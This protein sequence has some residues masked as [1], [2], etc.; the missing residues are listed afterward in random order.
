MDLAAYLLGQGRLRE[1]LPLYARAAQWTSRS[2]LAE[3]Y[4]FWGIAVEGGGNG[5]APDF[6]AAAALFRR[7]LA[8]RPI[9][10]AWVDLAGADNRLGQTTHKTDYYVEAEHAS[11]QA[12]ALAPQNPE[13]WN[14]LAVELNAQGKTVE[15]VQALKTAA[16]YA[17]DNAQIAA[18]LKAMTMTLKH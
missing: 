11:R 16:T 15:A 1:A 7:A 8:V 9:F 2:N 6:A 17:P 5:L 12:L 4:T 14:N 13:A 18:N 10:E 3:V